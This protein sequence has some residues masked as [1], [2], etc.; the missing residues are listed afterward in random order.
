[1]DENVGV[2][3]DTCHVWDAGYDIRNDLDGVL[4][5]FDREIGLERLRAILTPDTEQEEHCS[6]CG[7]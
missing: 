5:A 4:E 2:C 1:M 7:R 6:S 3:L